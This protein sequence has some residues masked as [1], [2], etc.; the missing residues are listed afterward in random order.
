MSLKDGL[1]SEGFNAGVDESRSSVP[2]QVRHGT[3][4]DVDARKENGG[5]RNNTVS[6][7]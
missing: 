4:K 5:L 3:P 7:K 6:D 1:I 2:A